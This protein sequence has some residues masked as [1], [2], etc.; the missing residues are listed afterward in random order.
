VVARRERESAV[1]TSF[2]LRPADGSQVLRHRPGQYLTFGI[3]IPGA[4]LPLKR[5]Y[6]ISCAPNDRSY[7][8]TV[9]REPGGV[10]SNWLHDEVRP[11]T[12]LQVAPPAGEFFLPEKPERPVVLLSG[13]VGLTPMVSMLEEIAARQPDLPTHYVHGAL[14]GATHAMR[15]QVQDLAARAPGVTVR[16]FYAEPGA[17]DRAGEHYDHQGM[18]TTDWL[19]DNTPAGEAEFYLCGPKPFLR[20]F[21]GGLARAGVPGERIHYEFFGPADELLAA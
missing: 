9:K 7:R 18:I 14:N 2:E 13:G 12:V 3:A 16:T 4:G 5:N 21:V 17:E 11:G 19:Q 6:S 10:V 15:R 20:T 1:I 8:I